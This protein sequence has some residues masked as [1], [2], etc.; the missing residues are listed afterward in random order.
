MDRRYW[1]YMLASQRNGT[2]YIGSTSELAQRVWQHKRHVVE[3]FTARYNVHHLVWFEEHATP[4]A[5]VTRERQLKKWN[6]E[7]KV[8]LIEASNPDWTDLYERI[9]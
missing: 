7:W 9:T 8:K 2:L 3:G 4:M 1:V 5:M 6:R